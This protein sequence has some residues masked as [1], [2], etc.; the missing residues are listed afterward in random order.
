MGM[1]IHFILSYIL[2][3]LPIGTNVDKIIAWS[4]TNDQDMINYNYVGVQKILFT[5]NLDGIVNCH[6]G[7]FLSENSAQQRSSC[8]KMKYVKKKLVQYAFLA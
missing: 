4:I 1:A 5:T 8:K 3:K 6:A 7:Y 2:Q